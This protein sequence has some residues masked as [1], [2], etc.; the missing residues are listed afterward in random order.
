MVFGTIY[1][2]LRPI[3][4]A[5]LVDPNDKAA[6][7]ASIEINTFLWG[8]MFNLIIPTFRRAPH[9]WREKGLRT[10]NAKSV[11]K[12]Y[13]D[14]YDPDYVVPVGKCA[15]YNLDIEKERVISSSGI[16]DGVEEDGLPKLGIGLFEVLRHLIEDELKFLRREPLDICL[17]NFKSPF[18][19][20][21]KSVLGSLPQNIEKILQKSFENI[22]GAKRIS[23]SI[24]NYCDFLTPSKLFFR[25]ISSLR[26]T[27]V[28]GRAWGE[29][30]CVFVLDASEPLD[31]IDYWNLRAFGW[32][33]LPVAKQAAESKGTR[34]LVVDFI[35]DNF[36]P[37]RL[38]PR[39]YYSTI[40]LKSRSL[41][42]RELKD[43]ASSLKISAPDKPREFK[44]VFQDWFPRMWANEECCELESRNERHDLSGIQ[45]RI[46]IK[47]LAPDFI[48]GFG[49]Y[50]GK[51]F[52][53]EIE[54]H[55]YGSKELIAEVIPEGNINPVKAIDSRGFGEWRFSKKGIVHLSS[56]LDQSIDF[57]LPKAEDMFT[58]WLKLKKWKAEISTSGHIA[59]QMLKQ[60]GGKW[61][62]SILANE[63]IIKLLEKMGGEKS[64]EKEA[65]RGEISK[66]AKQKSHT[67]DPNVILKGLTDVR[68]FRLGIELQCPICRQHSWYSIKDADYELQCPKCLDRFPLPSHSPKDIAWS[69]RTFG[70]FSLPNYAYGVYSILLTLRFFSQLLNGSTTPIVSFNAEKEGKKI[71]SDLALFFRKATFGRNETE[72]VFAECKTYNPFD[73]RDIGRMVF[74]ADEFPGAFL[75]FA[76]L[77]KSLT[78]KE[79]RLLRAVENRSR[80]NYKAR[81]LYNP[82]LILTGMELFSDFGLNRTWKEAGGKHGA[83]AKDWEF[84]DLRFLCD[85]TQQLYLD[86]KP[87]HQWF[88]EDLEKRLGGRVTSLASATARSEST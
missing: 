20:F 82:V 70:P 59:K 49:G 16:L 67:I 55:V 1:Q 42:E 32:N 75:V 8:G 27:P 17:P 21:L 87:L 83:L 28:S 45:E 77:R 62:I 24:G 33:V 37:D 3:K 54:L 84:T 9:V 15:G 44:Y 4:L 38:N 5:F 19:L 41:S 6:L 58:E 73:R 36:V 76:T 31:I 29:R 40:L 48:N 56:Y 14:A 43:F 2:K 50:G 74:L 47:T 88:E 79:K 39:F 22:L 85:A 72:L 61:G 78:Q 12:G 68:V 80:R 86:M 53:N 18:S 10:P 23:C 57:S 25:R 65:F 60:L 69:Y 35:E 13:L 34:Q 11:L 51:R 66:I 46:T 30:Q 63:G 64:L 52:A 71:E 7:L 26:I 81:R